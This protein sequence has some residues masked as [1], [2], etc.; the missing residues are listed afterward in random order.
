MNHDDEGAVACGRVMDPDALVGGVVMFHLA[1][2]R[3]EGRL[4]RARLP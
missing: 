2:N 3:Q 1:F 4:N